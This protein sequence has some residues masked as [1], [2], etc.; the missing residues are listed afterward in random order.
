MELDRPGTGVKIEDGKQKQGVERN[1]E[2]QWTGP[3]K[4]NEVGSFWQLSTTDG[5]I[6]LWQIPG[7]C[8]PLERKRC[9]GFE[10]DPDLGASGWSMA[11]TSKLISDRYFVR[12]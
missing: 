3:L 11:G 5:P 4:D 7:Q 1:S 12:V 6:H 9:Q 8:P 10:P 2:M